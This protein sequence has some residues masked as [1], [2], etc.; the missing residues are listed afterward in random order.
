[1]TFWAG[2]I[3]APLGQPHMYEAAHLFRT[4]FSKVQNLF[5]FF[6]EP[7]LAGFI[8]RFDFSQKLVG[9]HSALR[10]GDGIIGL[11]R[12]LGYRTRFGQWI[13]LGLFMGFA[14]QHSPKV[15]SIC[16]KHKFSNMAAISR[17]RIWQFR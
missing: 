13:S 17:L 7:R 1:M 16:L 10:T 4:I 5:G 11:R 8:L 12:P 9:F 2:S 14:K 15:G 6:L 3:L